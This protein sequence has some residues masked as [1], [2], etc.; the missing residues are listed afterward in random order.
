MPK[1][2]G[3]GE[4][5]RRRA[6]SGTNLVKVGVDGLLAVRMNEVSVFDAGHQMQRSSET[7]RRYARICGQP[8][9][10]SKGRKQRE[11]RKRRKQT[12]TPAEIPSNT[13]K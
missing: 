5:P 2:A 9:H 4:R 11:K 6:R 13:E 1:K 10:Y 12:K 3:R 8:S 7:A